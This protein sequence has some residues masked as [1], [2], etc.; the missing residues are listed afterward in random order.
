MTYIY[1]DD[2]VKALYDVNVFSILRISRAVIPYMAER[3]RGTI[4]IM[5]SVA[6]QFPTPWTGHYDASK[7]AVRIMTE[8]L[9]LECKPFNI[10]VMLVSAASVRSKIIGKHDNF[11]LPSESLYGKFFPNIRARL[12]AAR[13]KA[14]METGAFAEEIIS[15]ADSA[16]PP[17]YLLAGGKAGTYKLLSYLPRSWVLSMMWNMFSKPED[18]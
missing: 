15:K 10:K 14:A 3:K 18:K 4:V 12:E 6:G 9:G 7:A 17:S 13:D 1:T 16:N 11:Q 2:D 8:V 5:G